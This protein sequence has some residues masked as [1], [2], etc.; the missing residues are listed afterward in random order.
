[1]CKLKMI[2]SFFKMI[3]IPIFCL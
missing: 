2:L 1:M 3:F